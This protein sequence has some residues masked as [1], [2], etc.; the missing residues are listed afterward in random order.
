MR[1]QLRRAR[2]IWAAG[3]A[4]T[5]VAGSP[6]L[7]CVVV[8]LIILLVLGGTSGGVNAA[9]QPAPA[10]ARA[11][12]DGSCTD[13]SQSVSTSTWTGPAAPGL[14][15]LQTG[16]AWTI[17]QVARQK[18]LGNRGAAIGI[19][20]AMAEASLQNYANDGTS[21]LTGSFSDGH[22]QLNA[23]ERAV[24]RESLQY[25][26]DI[27]GNN[28]DSVGLFQQRPSAGWGKPQE[29]IVPAIAAGKFFDRLAKVPGWNTTPTP[30]QAGQTV[31][32]S[33]SEDGSIYRT[34]FQ[35]GLKIVASFSDSSQQPTV[36]S[37]ATQAP[38]TAISVPSQ[39]SAAPASATATNSADGC[40]NNT[41]V[42]PGATS[43]SIPNQPSVDSRLRDTTIHVPN[44]KIARGLAAGF[45][46][47]GYPYVWGG[48]GDG[49]GPNDGCSRGGGQQN[50]CQGL[51]GFDCSGLSAYVIVQAG[52]PSPGGNSSAQAQ[53]S[54]HVDESQGQAGDLVLFTGHVA[55]YLGRID[56]TPYILQ[57]ST[58]GVPIQIVPLT[59]TRGRLPGLYRYWA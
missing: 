57:A 32:G 49:A 52:Y 41:G 11:A 33:P 24:A 8:L 46:Y 12:T 5:T 4:I 43:I 25:P 45:K 27:V 56:G 20:V 30:W 37:A 44:T 6:L 17:T 38:T 31:Q 36:G 23:A 10:A 18:G 47:L 22:R 2:L 55:V 13:P 59:R 53:P 29:L 48:G 7:P 21:T 39:T 40:G 16:H 58:V 1:K 15:K 14:D 42:P 54:H 50:S 35:A 26:H 28:L 3:G 34:W 9:T 19:S 51:L